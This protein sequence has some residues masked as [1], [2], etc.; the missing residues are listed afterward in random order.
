MASPTTKSRIYGSLHGVAVVDAL[1]GPVEFMPRGCFDGVTGFAYNHTFNVP[2]GYV[3][4]LADGF[5]GDLQ[6]T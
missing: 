6:L 2:P 3:D 4:K 1:G 5:G